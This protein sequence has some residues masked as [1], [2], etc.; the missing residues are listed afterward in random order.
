[1][2]CIQGDGGG[3]VLVQPQ[4]LR[5]QHYYLVVE[6]F[7]GKLCGAEGA[8]YRVQSSIRYPFTRKSNAI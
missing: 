8:D 4:Y 2:C 6:R 3:E 5:D 1:L 7:V